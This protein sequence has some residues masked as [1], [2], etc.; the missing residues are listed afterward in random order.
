[1]P[2]YTNNAEL[3]ELV[4]SFQSSKKRK[5]PMPAEKNKR[6]VEVLYQIAGG[7]WDRYE[8]TQCREEFAQDCVTH[9]IDRA[10]PRVSPEKN[11]FAYL[12]TCA[13][14]HGQK[15]RMLDVRRRRAEFEYR[16]QRQA[17]Y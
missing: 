17:T 12:T 2:H 7:V 11:V 14:G 15:A 8:Y 10:L 3:S 13:I 6:L 16:E 5:R 9:F 1:M 4:K